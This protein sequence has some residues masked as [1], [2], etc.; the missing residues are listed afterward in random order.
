MR[1][2]CL[3]L[4]SLALDVFTRACAPDDARPFVVSSGG[5][6]PRVVAANDAARVA[7]IRR[8]QLISA[9]LALAPDVTLRDR[10]LAAETT[11]LGDVATRLLAF[12]PNASLALPDAVV[13][14]IARSARLFGGVPK[15]AEQLAAQARALGY[16]VVTAVAPTPTA[17]LLL[18]RGGREGC[19][20]DADTL[21][22]AL[23]PLPLASLDLDAEAIATLAAAGVATFGEA[24][25]LPRAGLARRFGAHV[26]DTLDRALGRLADPRAPYR[27]PPRFE[28]KLAL[29]APVESADA[30]RF[31]VHRV[32]DDLASWLLAR[33]LGVLRVTL[34]LVHERYLRER[35]VAPTVASFALAAPA[36]EPAHLDTVL[37][38]RLARV[39]LPAP[40]EAIVLASDETT[41]LASRNLGLLPGDDAAS[42]TV[43]LVERLRSRLGDAAVIT[44]ATH[45]EHRPELAGLEI[46]SQPGV[47]PA[48][49]DESLLQPPRP[50]W[51]LDEP[52][53]LGD[54][55]AAR[56]WVLRDGPERI[57][58]GWW[59]GRDCR[60]DYFV[61]ESAHGEIVWIYRDHRYGTDDGEWFMHGLFA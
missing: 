18:A 16:D 54:A 9:A 41:P 48:T 4:R 40:V 49:H 50:L 60:R 13:A 1:Y 61:A 19:F 59:D 43:P 24:A 28:R 57:E 26:V 35:G 20:V 6:D 36:R 27:P 32:V 47:Q 51:L 52:R 39:V 3:R 53:A 21:A 2:A 56:P 25:R 38:E 30:L 31:A 10:D 11:A 58:S 45:D 37:R 46:A 42:A 5:H 12:T 14:E 8:S 15:L 22:A 23:A 33:G 7:G 29:P 17:A 44:L 55:F 34:S